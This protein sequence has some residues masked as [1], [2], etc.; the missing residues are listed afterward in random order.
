MIQSEGLALVG[1]DGFI[2]AVTKQ[3]AVIKHGN[4]GFLTGE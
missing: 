4:F 1:A 3:K 2:E